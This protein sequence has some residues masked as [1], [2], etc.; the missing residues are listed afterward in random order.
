[1]GTPG[2]V[3]DVV[4]IGGGPAGCAAAILCAQ[5][6]L[7]VTLLEAKAFPRH[8]PGETLHPGVEPVLRQ[9][10]AFD[11]VLAAGFPRHTGNW[12]TWA[13]PTR[14][15]AFGG[16]ADG[17]WRGFQAWRE[18]LDALLLERAR[19]AGVTIRQPCTALALRCAESRVTGVDTS[20]GPIAAAFVVDAGGS[21]HWLARQLGLTIRPYSPRLIAR[22][23]YATGNCAARDEAPAIAADEAGWTWTARIRV[24]VYQWTRVAF[25]EE[26]LPRD[27]MPAELRGLAPLGPMRAADVT[28][29]KVE[30]P[31]GAGY[32]VVGDAAATLDPAASH[33][34][35]KGLMSGM[36]AAYLITRVCGQPDAATTAVAA[37]DAWLTGW[38]E[39]DVAKLHELYAVTASGREWLAGFAPTPPASREA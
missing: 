14:F 38:F 9:L 15:E 7:R 13:A 33:G 11:A 1:M 26:K 22:Y 39:T 8:R 37:Y 31:A 30:A 27:W 34:V 3:C 16:D 18:T 35:L 19:A 12:I 23:G 10:G 29:R 6:G 25:H 32:F 21:A 2:A 28:W 36:M 5:Q 24:G 17:P 4:V 20:D